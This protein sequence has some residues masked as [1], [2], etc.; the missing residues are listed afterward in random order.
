MNKKQL[1]AEVRKAETARGELA[2]PTWKLM[3]LTRIE[4]E[5]RLSELTT[6][7][8]RAPGTLAKSRQAGVKPGFRRCTRCDQVSPVSEFGAY[9]PSADGSGLYPWDKTCVKAYRA[10]RKAATTPS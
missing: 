5:E 2:T 10:E 3:E 1:A 8:R 6:P 4:L 9:A 7:S